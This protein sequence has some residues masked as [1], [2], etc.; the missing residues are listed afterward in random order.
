MGNATSQPPKNYSRNVPMN[1]KQVVHEGEFLQTYSNPASGTDKVPM[2]AGVA[3]MS[4]GVKIM[5]SVSEGTDY[6]GHKYG[7]NEMYVVQ[8][9]GRRVYLTKGGTYLPNADR[10]VQTGKNYGAG[11]AVIVGGDVGAVTYTV[12]SATSTS[13]GSAYTPMRINNVG[14]FQKAVWYGHEKEQKGKYASSYGSAAINPFKN[15]PRNAFST[16]ADVGRGA[17]QV[18]DAVAVPIIEYGL[19]AVTDDLGGTLMQITGLDDILQKNLDT[20]TDLHGI[21]YNPSAATT[22]AYLSNVMTDPRLEEVF[23]SEMQISRHK[24]YDSSQKTNAYQKELQKLVNGR[25]LD[26]ASKLEAMRKLK[27]QNYRYD[28]QSQIDVLG[29]TV[30]LLKKMVPNPPGMSWK[31]IELGLT[32]PDPNFQVEF[33]TN[34]TDKIMKNVVPLMKQKSTDEHQKSAPSPA[35]ED[36]KTTP[37]SGSKVGSGFINGEESR[38]QHPS[39]IKGF[40]SNLEPMRAY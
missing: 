16:L 5:Q 24:A 7:A 1:K 13:P 28:A 10:L 37:D 33:A 15:R 38:Y 36:K 17:L 34:I 8:P 21:D 19:D 40:I 11:P 32:N 39:R 27:N 26:N 12:F 29:K 22:Q 4:L 35:P 20:L 23:H 3:P 30:A 18:I 25:Y 14:D 31:N 2:G 9:S 6:Q